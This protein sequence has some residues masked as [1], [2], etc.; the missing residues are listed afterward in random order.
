MAE[1]L[2]RRVA[3]PVPS[4]AKVRILLGSHFKF[5]CDHIVFRSHGRMA[6]RAVGSHDRKYPGNTGRWDRIPLGPHFQFFCQQQLL[7]DFSRIVFR[8]HGQSRRYSRPVPR[9]Q[10]QRERWFESTWDRK[11]YFFLR[12]CPFFLV[13]HHATD[14]WPWNSPLPNSFG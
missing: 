12:T 14:Q 8:S 7:H 11:L 4:G 6:V 13:H 9:A 3:N 5:F 10:G 2:R 1:W